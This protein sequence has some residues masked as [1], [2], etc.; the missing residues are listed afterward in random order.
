MNN[1]LP[2]TAR[3]RKIADALEASD[4]MVEAA[5]LHAAAE[6]IER[7]RAALHETTRILRNLE[8]DGTQPGADETRA[9][10]AMADAA[11]AMGR[12]TRST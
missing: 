6:L 11:L 3:L 9:A 7:Q 8:A 1:N 4:R 2:F 12:G 10:L 5:E